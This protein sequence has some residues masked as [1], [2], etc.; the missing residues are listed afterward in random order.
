MMTNVWVVSSGEPVAGGIS[1]WRDSNGNSG[2]AV[3]QGNGD[4]TLT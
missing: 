1:V 3:S 4:W 2:Q